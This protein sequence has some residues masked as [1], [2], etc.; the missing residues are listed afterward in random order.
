MQQ[1]TSDLPTQPKRDSFRKYLDDAGVIDSL[2]RTIV[3]LYDKTKLPEDITAFF[4]EFLGSPQGVNIESLKQ[5][6]AQL[7]E[8]KEKLEKRVQELKSQL[9]I[10]E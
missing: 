4:K 2:T 10:T 6:N 8:E 3:T 7:K 9:G 1:T 5:E